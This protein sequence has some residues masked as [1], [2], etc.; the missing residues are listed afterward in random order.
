ME[1]AHACDHAD[2]EKAL[3]LGQQWKGAGYYF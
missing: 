3:K 1:T 2:R